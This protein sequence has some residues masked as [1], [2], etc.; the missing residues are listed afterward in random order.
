MEPLMAHVEGPSMKEKISPTMSSLL[1]LNCQS[2]QSRSL[3]RVSLA[4]FSIP[5]ESGQ[6]SGQFKMHEI[7]KCV[8]ID[9]IMSIKLFIS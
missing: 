4:D 8:S 5:L 3:S 2:P 7:V 6:F 1:K 9:S